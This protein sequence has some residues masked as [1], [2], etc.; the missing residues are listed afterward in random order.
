LQLPA[1][2]VPV[3]VAVPSLT[4]TFPVGVPPLDVTVNVTA[5]GWPVTDGLGVCPLMVVVVLAA[6]TTTVAVCVI[7]TPL[8]VAETVFDSAALEDNAPV[9]TPPAV[10][11]LAG[12]V[13]VFPLP[14]AASC[15]VAP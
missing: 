3:H 7:A 6:L 11:V 8:I 4:V 2:T 12:W 14:V 10:V 9:A 13:S 15:T 1:A 5:T